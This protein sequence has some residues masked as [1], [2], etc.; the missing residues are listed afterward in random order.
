MK[1]LSGLAL[2][3]VVAGFR[4]AAKSTCSCDDCHGVWARPN[5]T[6]PLGL[7]EKLQCTSQDSECSGY[8]GTSC[9]AVAPSQPTKDVACRSATDDKRLSLAQ[10]KA[11]VHMAARCPDPSPCNCQCNCPEIVYGTPPPVPIGAAMPMPGMPGMFGL[12]QTGVYEAQMPPTPNPFGPPP[13]MIPPPPPPPDPPM[14]PDP[15]ITPCPE[16]APC[17]CYCHCRRPPGME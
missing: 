9:S 10:I 1:L 14:P 7:A 6:T 8:C 12:L 4:L 3:Q 15:R 13:P 11:M 5:G 17:T 16:V 2:T